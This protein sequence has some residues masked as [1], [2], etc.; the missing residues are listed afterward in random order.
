ME[1]CA[2]VQSVNFRA[3]RKIVRIGGLP[4]HTEDRVIASSPGLSASLWDRL[5][6]SDRHRPSL[7]DQR[8]SRHPS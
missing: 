3:T 2:F 8:A 1:I 7:A 6:F 4:C 5:A